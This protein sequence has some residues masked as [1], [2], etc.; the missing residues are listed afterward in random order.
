MSG[1]ELLSVI[2]PVSRPEQLAL[3]APSVPPAAEW[4]LVT[5]GPQAIPP[6]L[7]AH[8]LID[9]P[10]TGRW[11]DA[12]RQ[13]GLE[14]ATRPFACFLDDDN[15]MLP[16]LGEL[17]IGQ[18]QATGAPGALFGLL[19][20]NPGGF[21]IWP[22]PIRVERSQ[23]DTAMFLGRTELARRVGWPDFATDDGPLR[24][25]QRCA[26]YYFISAFDEQ[27]PL[28]RL[29]AIYGFHDGLAILRHHAPDTYAALQAN[30]DD[31]PEQLLA[32]LHRHMTQADSPPW[33]KGA[34]AARTSRAPT[35]GP[36]AHELLELAGTVREGSSMPAQRAHYQ[37][38]VQGLVAD[39]PGQPVNVLEAGFNAGLSAAAFLEAS[40]QVHVVSCDL[41]DH[42]IVVACAEHLRSRFADRLHLVMGD[43][44]E[45]L[46]R[47]G[48]EAGAR[49]DLVLID[50][51][52]DE[53]T[54]RA[55]V[56]NARTVAG[57]GA[58]VIVDDLMPHKPYGAGVCRA[59]DALLAQ[60]VLTSPQIWRTRPGAV[61]FEADTGEPPEGCDR[62]WGVA[63]F[64]PP[65]A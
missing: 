60:D 9:G 11:G 30:A 33:W 4:I 24:A 63:R 27:A 16:M 1:S 41:A 55:D 49:F 7:R 13:I 65:P 37:A 17:V 19:L 32:M 25:G 40:A 23:V 5:D 45:T 28:L 64:G 53:A 35:A 38:L 2:T 6:G 34:L 14:A 39:R 56:I 52:H 50:G 21:F 10:P 29:P 43:T 61:T 62:R 42:P 18:L 20:R 48:T 58:V 59:W 47:F 3:I 8:V 26:D 36:V 22:P 12:Q 31:V 57:P 51:G 46:P 44:R 54:C 15:V